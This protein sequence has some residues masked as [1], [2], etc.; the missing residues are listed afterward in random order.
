[1]FET[2]KA[3]VCVEYGEE[4]VPEMTSCVESDRVLG[5]TFRGLTL[6]PDLS[7]SMNGA[8]LEDP[9]HTLGPASMQMTSGALFRPNSCLSSSY[10]ERAAWWTSMLPFHNSSMLLSQF[11]SFLILVT[12]ASKS[13]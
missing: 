12:M 1:M 9:I 11:N 4:K 3:V 13:S 5:A 6:G 7:S 8:F 2:L 10:T